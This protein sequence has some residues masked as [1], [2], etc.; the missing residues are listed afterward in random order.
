V[1]GSLT[2]DHVNSIGGIYFYNC[3][4]RERHYRTTKNL[5]G[6]FLDQKFNNNLPPSVII[7]K[8]FPA[9]TTFVCW[10]N[11][12]FWFAIFNMLTDRFSFSHSYQNN[13]RS[14]LKSTIDQSKRV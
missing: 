2:A 6:T 14:T 3:W 7:L 4:R 1:M 12:I 11:T 5:N 10:K 13:T 9:T 8:K